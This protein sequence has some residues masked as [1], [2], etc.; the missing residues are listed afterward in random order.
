MAQ[1]NGN[2]APVEVHNN[3]LVVDDEKAIRELIR[4]ALTM[5]GYQVMLA[6]TPSEALQIFHENDI[7]VV[8]ADWRLPE[9]DGIELVTRMKTKSPY[10]GAI[11]MTGYGTKQTIIDAFTHGK[12]NY[13]LPK[14]FQVDKL[15]EVTSAAAQEH[16][17]LL[18]DKRFR[19][20]LEQEIKQATEELEVK[21][22]LLEDHQT[23]IQETKDYLENLIESSVDAIIST[24]QKCNISLFS[25]G[26]EEMFG[27]N[28]ESYLGAPLEILFANGRG[29]LD[30][31]LDLLTKKS[32][33][34]NLEVEVIQSDGSHLFT[35]ISI[36]KLH[37]VKDRQGFLLI[38]KDLSERKR[39]EEELLASNLI[40]KK[41]SVTD[42]LTK[43][44][45]R[46]FFE[47]A[48]EDEF[49]RA[50]RFNSPI[51]L[52]ILD[53]DD[54][55]RINDTYGHQTGDEILIQT[56]SLITESIRKI[57]IPARYGGEEFAVILPQTR[58]TDTIYVAER[59]KEAFEDFSKTQN[60]APGLPVTASLGLS[61]R[62]DS[63]G[64][65]PEDLIRFADQALYRAKELGKNR[66]VIGRTSGFEPLGRGERLT[67]GEKQEILRRISQKL[68]ITIKLDEILNHFLE[69]ITSALGEKYP[70]TPISIMLTDENQKLVTRAETRMDEQRRVEFEQLAQKAIAEKQIHTK[71]GNNKTDSCSSYPIIIRTPPEKEEAIGVVNIGIVPTDLEFFQDMINSVALG[72]RNAKLYDEM[73]FSKAALE[74]K[75]NEL[76]YLSFLSM[77][78]QHNA[79]IMDD[80]EEENRK[81]L[82]K[83]ISQ[84]GFDRVL[85]FD[86]DK[87]SNRLINGVDSRLAADL[88][89]GTVD[90][91]QLS[92]ESYLHSI[93]SQQREYTQFSLQAISPDSQMESAERGVLATLGIIDGVIAVAPLLIRD[94]VIGVV[95]AHKEFMTPEDLEALAI[96]VIHSSLIMENLDLSVSYQDTIKRFTLVDD[97]TSNF[98]VANTPAMIA[99]AT[100]KALRELIDQLDAAAL[101]VYAYDSHNRDLNSVASVSGKDRSGLSGATVQKIDNTLNHFIKTASQDHWSE[102][103]IIFDGATLESEGFGACLGLPLLTRGCFCGI[104]FIAGHKNQIAFDNENLELAKTVSRLLAP[105][106]FNLR[107]L[108][109]SA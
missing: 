12:I 98:A 5:V 70:N 100:E 54:F 106:L 53:L 19:E 17:M 75:V 45:N 34:T 21:T 14:P 61:G 65:S 4:E 51:G 57:D 101:F 22:Q 8:L 67:Y 76:T 99:K 33:L 41:L 71:N 30:R 24:D 91:S 66:I 79:R 38:I 94:N 85:Y 20:R 52:I 88:E 102:P 48:L 25:R 97:I 87:E 84:I 44:N 31:M 42:P 36:S 11:L 92:A 15:L 95:I 1:Q 3:I 60:I 90:L 16:K 55:K 47:E 28:A 29:E 56:T 62:P 103:M 108:T 6:A 68:R 32:R 69:E 78:L 73:K 23:Q 105:T 7:D 89:L 96:Y 2:S 46:R 58:L 39:L 82:T 107:P 10:L 93:L 43:L 50:L 27:D 64:D 86:Y 72:I 81:L 104:L 49:Q 77:G 37:G 109:A 40:L 13:Y 74:K 9:M 35:D 59:I 63:G 18:S 83:C 26:A 80:Y